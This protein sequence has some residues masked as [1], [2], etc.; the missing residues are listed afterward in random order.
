MTLISIIQCGLDYKVIN[1]LQK[2]I[3]INIDDDNLSKFKLCG[4]D[5]VNENDNLIKIIKYIDSNLLYFVEKRDSYLLLA[6][7]NY[8]ILTNSI[9][10]KKNDYLSYLSPSQIIDHLDKCK[11]L[12]NKN[13]KKYNNL[14]FNNLD[15]IEN[16]DKKII[17]LN[18]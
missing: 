8:I 5:I 7:N 14:H 4:L 3:D 10:A 13:I 18:N 15:F 11:L 1:I 2:K 12:F 9:Y 17:M 6:L 16:W